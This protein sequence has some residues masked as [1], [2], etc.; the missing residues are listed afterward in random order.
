MINYRN[1]INLPESL[2]TNLPPVK[3][4]S[5]TNFIRVNNVHTI[6][7]LTNYFLNNTIEIEN[8]K[9][10]NIKSNMSYF[11]EKNKVSSLNLGCFRCNI[12]QSDNSIGLIFINDSTKLSEINLTFQIVNINFLVTELLV[13]PE[14]VMIYTEPSP[15][16]VIAFTVKHGPEISISIQDILDT[17]KTLVTPEYINTK[18]EYAAKRNKIVKPTAEEKIENEESMIDTTPDL[19]MDNFFNT[20]GEGDDIIE[21]LQENDVIVN[22][23]ID[24]EIS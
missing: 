7:A 17:Y 9:L 23:E 18:I 16:Y 8:E 19:T 4:S 20:T 24:I 6:L 2:D 10:N 14:L 5:K 3:A 13:R 11:L 22:E 1:T 21:Q 12:Y 15:L